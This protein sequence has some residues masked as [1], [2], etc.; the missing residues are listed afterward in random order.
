MR[1]LWE[2][3]FAHH[4]SVIVIAENRRCGSTHKFPRLTTV[5]NLDRRLAS[6]VN[7]SDGEMLHV[8]LNLGVGKLATNKS[9]CVEDSVPRVHYDL[10]LCGVTNETLFLGGCDIGGCCA[11]VARILREGFPTLVT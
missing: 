10:V 7:D 6:T 2:S 1:I 8:R 9:F 3:S 5:L 4:V 11:G